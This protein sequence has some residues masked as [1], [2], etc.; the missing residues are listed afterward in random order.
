MQ[1]FRGAIMGRM[2]V[3]LGILFLLPAALLVQLVRI[4][5]IEGD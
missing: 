2:F 5:F 4:N 1:E 3:M